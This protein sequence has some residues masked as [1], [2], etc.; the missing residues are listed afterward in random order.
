MRLEL[1]V[2]NVLHKSE[3]EK[4]FP[5]RDR[6]F[7]ELV[8]VMANKESKIGEGKTAIVHTLKGNER[9][10]MKI[11]S[12]Q[13]LDDMYDYKK[14]IHNDLD[15]E[16]A[17]L[18][19]AASYAGEVKIPLPY[20]TWRFKDENGKKLDV[21]LMECLNAVSLKQ[22]HELDEPLPEGFDIES[23]FSKLKATLTRLNEA[24]I[25]HRDVAISNIL[26]TRDTAEPCLIDFGDSTKPVGDENHLVIR[27]NFGR[28][29]RTYSDDLQAL[30][31]VKEQLQ[32]K[33]EV[34][35]NNKRM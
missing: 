6:I 14:P 20:L 27:D 25:Y 5:D 2:E 33:L 23:F 13:R 16:C 10:C 1:G 30:D 15:S 22:I 12:E 31:K 28:V 24:N 29:I 34:D 9:C 7:V 3:L 21:L 11:V 8:E 18:E 32:H 17:F 35:K 4:E 26:V 19:A